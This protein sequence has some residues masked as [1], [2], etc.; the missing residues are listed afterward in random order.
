MYRFQVS[1]YEEMLL[2][3]QEQEKEE[4]L[5]LEAKREATR[6]RAEEEVRIRGLYSTLYPLHICSYV[7]CS[8]VEILLHIREL[9]D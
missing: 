7:C 5:A 1:L 4:R 6:M 3:Q 9:T 2:R 8:I